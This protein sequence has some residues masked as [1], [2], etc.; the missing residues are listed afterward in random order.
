MSSFNRLIVRWLVF[1]VVLMTGTVQA[2]GALESTGKR[3]LDRSQ[4]T[5]VSL[6]ERVEKVDALVSASMVEHQVSPNDRTPDPV[7]LRRIYLQIVGRI[8]TLREATQFLRSSSGTK[9]RDLIDQLLKSEGY[10]SREFNYWADLLRI[11]SRMR[12]APGKPYL[13]W[14]K[15]AF[16]ENKPYDEMVR[17]LITAE[18]YIWDDG[19]AGYYLR[20]A[21]MPLDH[22]ANTFQVF[23]G[24]QL[25]CA[26]CHDHPYDEFTQI[27]YYQQAAYIYGVKTTDRKAVEKFRSFGRRKNL[28]EMSAETRRVARQMVRPLRY[29]VNETRSKLRLPDDYQYDDAEPKSVIE[30]DTIFG[31]EIHL[32][33]GQSPRDGYARW[34][35]SEENPRFATVIANRLWKRAM[36]VGI[37][38]P[39]DD[40][41]DGYSPSH[42]GLMEYLTQLMVDLDFNLRDYLR[43]LYNTNTYQRMVSEEEWEE[44]TPYFFP[45]PVL[46]RMSAEQLWD[47]L[48]GLVVTDLDER[49]GNPGR[50]QRYG[51]AQDLVGM[52]PKEILGLAEK[53]SE[54]TKRGRALREQQQALR[55]RLKVAERNNRKGQVRQ[56]RE[57]QDALS[58]EIRR[59]NNQARY[60]RR[61]GRNRR[62]QSD[63]P[64]WKG[65]PSEMVRASEIQSPAPPRH[66]LRQF[67][68][69]D[70]ETIEN[71]NDEASVPQ[72][73]TLLN[74]PFYQRLHHEKS[75]YQ[76]TLA[77]AGQ[78]N[79]LLDAIYLSLLTRLPSPEERALIVPELRADR[80][81][82]VADLTWALLN[83]RQFSFVQ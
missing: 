9:R 53:R 81:T 40:L 65:I 16:R 45:G 73:L 29:R 69:S 42:P 56:L 74:G 58:K 60:G 19:A 5:P 83:T 33:E 25:V 34:L 13:D 26:Q 70:R 78:P 22:M 54:A 32:D 6:K 51:Q 64:R 30:P 71:A 44:G 36:G 31:D 68:Q 39:V 14:V 48:M 63:D 18:G 76:K 50:N 11:Q 47:S 7:F 12:N 43:V 20:D 8:P 28:D 52:E 57:Q 61:N 17:E 55:R 15:Q 21:G 49:P 46:Q 10:V 38:E 4:L 79:E 80:R 27:D 24:T 1:A 66:F 77:Q 67:G 2:A 72:I 59:V 23:L 41:S 37:I 62:P 35:T 75:L 82:V 3:G